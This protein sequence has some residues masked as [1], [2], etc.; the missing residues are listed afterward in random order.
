MEAATNTSDSDVDKNK[1][2]QADSNELVNPDSLN[3]K[4]ALPQH[5]KNH[6]STPPADLASSPGATGSNNSSPRSSPRQCVYFAQGT[7]RFGTAC[8]FSHAPNAGNGTVGN[9][10]SPRQPQMQ[11]QMQGQMQGQPPMNVNMGMPMQMPMQNAFGM[12]PAAP[13]GP[14]GPAAGSPS[15]TPR[16]PPAPYFVQI[17]PG[18]PVFAIDVECVATGIQHNARS[19]AQVAVVDEWS[20]PIFNV[21]VKQDQPVLSYITELTGLTQ[22]IL[23]ERGQPLGKDI[24]ALCMHVI[25]SICD[26]SV[27][28]QLKLWQLSELLSLPLPS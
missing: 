10:P 3:L 23:D 2:G 11:A 17:P 13:T 7:C 6:A 1:N 18:H 22:Q 15:T 12:P 21:Y 20:R 19:V 16:A 8:R 27:V 28:V 14:G 26:I 25:R 5:L 4:I 24:F 9:K